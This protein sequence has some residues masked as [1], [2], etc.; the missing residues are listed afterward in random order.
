MAELALIASDTQEVLG[1]AVALELL[2][3]IPMIW[4]VLTS[5]ALAFVSYKFD[6]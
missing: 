5:I 4:G 2:F 6:S 1:A 3:G